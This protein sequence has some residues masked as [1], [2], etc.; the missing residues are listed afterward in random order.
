MNARITT[1]HTQALAA[2][3]AEIKASGCA[4]SVDLTDDEGNEIHCKVF[5]V[6][7]TQDG[8][9]LFGKVY[10]GCEFAYRLD[11]ITHLAI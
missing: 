9:T 1:D 3:R 5:E 6:D 8:I 2:I 4:H 11:E 10:G 7:E